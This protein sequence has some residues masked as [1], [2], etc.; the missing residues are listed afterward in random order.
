MALILNIE[1]TSDVCSV[2]LSR[3]G[4]LINIQEENEGRSHAAKLAVFIDKVLKDEKIEV[5][6]LDAVSISKGPG[7]YTGLRIG[8]STAKGLCYGSDLPLISVHT[9]QTLTQGLINNIRSYFPEGLEKGDI[10]VPMIDARRMEVYTARFDNRNNFLRDVEPVI[11]EDHT[12]Q[13]LLDERRVIFI[14]NGIKKAREIINHHH[15]K[16]IEA[17]NFSAAHMVSLSE[18]KFVKGK[19]EDV[20]YFEPFYLKDFQATKPKNKLF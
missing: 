17:I 16:F 2:A 3:D 6:H 14:G 1:T 5:S 10:L 12:F 7:S 15:A 20:A 13:E 18:E 4:K 11:L 9:L 8:V 19:F